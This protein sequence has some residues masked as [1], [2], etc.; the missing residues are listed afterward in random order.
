MLCGREA[1]KES[2]PPIHSPSKDPSEY[3]LVILGTPVWAGKMS[4][5]LRSY[6]KTTAGKF[7]TVAFFCTYKAPAEKAP[8]SLSKKF[9]PRKLPQRSIAIRKKSSTIASKPRSMNFRIDFA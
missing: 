4:S 8:S 9:F 7:K 2:E 1:L 3:D 5:P 6:I